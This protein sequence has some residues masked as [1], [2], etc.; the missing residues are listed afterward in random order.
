MASLTYRQGTEI[1][2]ELLAEWNWQLIR[3]EGHR[4][5]MTPAELK[6]RMR[7][8]LAADYAAHIFSSDGKDVAYCL[9]RDDDDDGIFLRQFFVHR[10]HRRAGIGRAAMGILFGLWR[11][12]RLTVNVLC[13]NSAAVNFYRSL[14]YRDYYL[15]L[16]VIPA[17]LRANTR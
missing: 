11:G 1:D 8:W 9:H 3:D 6:E 14:G 7:G 17:G 15:C 4:N 16:E 5:R 13:G 2:L 12:K 10:E